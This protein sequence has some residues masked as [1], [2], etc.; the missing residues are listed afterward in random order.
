MVLSA[1]AVIRRAIPLACAM[2]VS[3]VG[4]GILH[5]R[6]Q[7][8]QLWSVGVDASSTSE[9]SIKDTRIALPAVVDDVEREVRYQHKQDGWSYPAPRHEDRTQLLPGEAGGFCL[10]ICSCC[11]EDGS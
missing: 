1:R 4:A 11:G 7:S 3:A 6:I 8:F 9:A 5:T 10:C 2:G